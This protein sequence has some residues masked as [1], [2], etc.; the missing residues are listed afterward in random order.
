MKTQ[1]ITLITA[2]ALV[3]CSSKFEDQDDNP[4]GTNSTGTDADDT[5]DDE[6]DPNLA[7]ADGDGVAIAD[8]DCDDDNADVFPGAG[9]QCDGIDNDCDDVI[10]EG[11]EKDTYYADTDGDEHGNPNRDMEACEQPDG[12]V[13]DNTDCNDSD[14]EVYPGAEEVIGDD[15]DNDC[16]G[17]KD[18]RFDI[19]S[20][21]TDDDDANFGAPSAIAVDGAGAAHVVFHDSYYGEVLY[22]RI[23]PEGSFMEETVV[24]ADDEFDGG[25]LDAEVDS[26]G[27]LHIGYTSAMEL[28]TATLTSLKYTTRSASGVWSPATTITGGE[29]GENDRGQY[30]DI[31]IQYGSITGPT[32]IFAFLDNDHGT[33]MIADMLAPDLC[34]IFPAGTSYMDALTGVGSGLFTAIDVDATGSSHV[35]FFDPNAV[36]IDGIDFDIFDPSISTPQIQYTNWTW[37]P[38]DIIET[39]S[40][41]DL[42][43]EYGTFEETVS[44]SNYD[45]ISLKS[46]N[47]DQ[48]PCFATQE[49][50]SR[51]LVFGCREA[52]GWVMETVMS[53]GVTGGQPSLAINDAD[54]YFI[55][56]YNEGTKDLMLA[57][58]RK[59]ADWEIITVDAEGWVGKASSIA[60]GPDNRI[61]ISYYDESNRT[62]RYAVGY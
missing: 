40:V 34:P 33:P 24:V 52:D 14:A 18:E 26:S 11:W 4:G 35:A 48:V 50:G 37:N 30:V 45:T 16:D 29:T 31:A 6:V 19:S 13:L 62:L 49:L 20:V 61:H 8:G 47:A 10:D 54:E 57:M 43:P 38:D 1:I 36:D 15:K 28:P 53:E 5:D 60:I 42:L 59:E 3:G 21:Q 56:F 55:S 46:R 51:D 58:K 41:G 44:E 12:Y 32:P 7:D 17:N 27:K 25:H 2:L 22:Q 23:S 9:D 39:L